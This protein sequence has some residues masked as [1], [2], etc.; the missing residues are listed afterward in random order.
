MGDDSHMAQGQIRAEVTTLLGAWRDGDELARNRLISVIYDELRRIAAASLKNEAPGHTMQPTDLVH[1]LYL[2][3]FQPS[4]LKV[5]DRKHLFAIAARQVRRILVD[6]AR[7]RNA[8]K[9]GGGVLVDLSQTLEPATKPQDLLVIDEA[10]SKL[11]E[12]DERAARVVELR[13]F[14]GTTE[15]ETADAL[16]ISVNS[17]KRDWDFARAWLHKALNHNAGRSSQ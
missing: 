7:S 3:I 17:V 13:F 4:P 1:E 12:L 11:A 8:Q 6:H 9:R 2:R 5:V 10:L 16:E 14:A 15:Q